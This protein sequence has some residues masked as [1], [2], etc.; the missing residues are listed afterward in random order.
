MTY[1][2]LAVSENAF[3]QQLAVAYVSHGYWFY[4][5]GIVPQNKNAILV[6]S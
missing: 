4:V 1:N 2:Y 5:A 6:D 3:V